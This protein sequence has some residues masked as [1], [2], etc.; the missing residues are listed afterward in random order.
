MN[1]KDKYRTIEYTKYKYEGRKYNSD[2][3]EEFFDLDLSK[4]L[5]ENTDKIINSQNDLLSYF[6]FSK[7]FRDFSSG[8]SQ[9]QNYL[10][11]FMVLKNVRDRNQLLK[12]MPDNL[13]VSFFSKLYIELYEKDNR[14]FWFS[15]IV[16]SL[17][18]R[19]Q[20]PFIKSVI[21]EITDDELLYLIKD[22]Y[23]NRN[24]QTLRALL[25]YKRFIDVAVNRV[26][27]PFFYEMIEELNLPAPDSLIEKRKERQKYIVDN[28]KDYKTAIVKDAYCDLLFHNLPSN[29]LLDLKTIIEFANADK[30]LRDN[31]LKDI[32]DILYATYNSLT[33][34][35]FDPKDLM[36]T[37]INYEVIAKSYTLCQ[38]R[39]QDLV[40]Q[41]INKDITDG[42]EP[43]TLLSSNDIPVKVYEIENQTE[44][45]KNITML[46]S[47]IPSSS[48]AKEF[49]N[50][51]CSN[52]NGEITKGRR[53]CSIVDE[54]HLN[55][56]FG[57]KNRIVLG[58]DDI[59]GRI[60][61]S[62]TLGDGRTDGNEIRYRKHRKVN[63]SSF[64]PISNFIEN[65]QSH[66]ELTINMGTTNQVMQPSYLLVTRTPTQLE[67]D[68]AAEFQI[69]I[70]KIS[71]DKYEQKP[72]MPFISEDYDYYHFEKEKVENIGYDNKKA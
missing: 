4:L 39:F 14:P 20:I 34:E 8:I 57:G 71:I 22:L 9:I 38:K 54:A 43:K 46:L 12:D 37:P 27:A 65:T 13:E 18:S 25:S 44:N 29:V 17:K 42:I 59:S 68:I 61:T 6:D 10:L 11:K 24:D 1:T 3:T 32:Y 31:Y 45:Q 41:S 64:L 48:N 55:L 28:S 62:A 26:N 72:H 70:R 56:L 21:S 35:S 50:I 16:N 69:P 15:S 23:E 7:L 19:N 36:A 47:T 67:I 2:E 58:Y 60:I 63:R 52:Q 5:Y 53:S 40:S 66:N 49:K 33:S 30:T 51:Y